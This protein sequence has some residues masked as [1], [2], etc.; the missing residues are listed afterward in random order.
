VSDF[1]DSL[2]NI[3]EKF[4]KSGNLNELFK[5]RYE[6]IKIEVIKIEDE[7]KKHKRLADAWGNAHLL[8]GVAATFL[9]ILSVCFTFFEKQSISAV[10]SILSSL[11]AG[12]LTYL[13][14]SRR[15]QKRREI[16]KLYRMLKL[17]VE[18]A[19][20]TIY[21]TSTNETRKQ[22]A[23]AG[24]ERGLESLYSTLETINAS[25]VD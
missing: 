14:P 21:S 10:L 2:K 17:K 9:S 13:N 3:T 7:V 12:F 1:N 5:K 16:S 24:L 4:S 20:V 25:I 23:L 11:A 15:E 8:L 22:E 18:S 6:D 19:E